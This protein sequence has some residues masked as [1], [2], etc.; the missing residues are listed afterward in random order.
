[1]K[2][3]TSVALAILLATILLANACTERVVPV[4]VSE[5]RPTLAAGEVNQGD[6]VRVAILAIRSAVAAQAQYGPLLDYLS[7]QTG[8]PFVF[9]PV[10]Q[11]DQF[12]VVERGKVDFTF[13]NPLAAV[14]IRRL[15][16]TDFLATLSRVN[17]GPEFSALIITRADSDIEAVE[18]LHDRRV[19]CV[20]HE[21]A[22]AGCVFQIFHLMEAGLDPFSDFATF[23]EEPS[24]DNIVLGVLN[25]TWDAG[26]V[27]TSHRM[28]TGGI[29]AIHSGWKV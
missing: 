12:T 22:A 17:T 24:Q 23:D 7:A 16:D 2:H 20:D 3:S 8:R 11:E 28:L 6:E 13:N 27:R 26:F 18:G 10:G 5:L 29:V 19:A 21:T 25:G 9:V 15:Y 1:M 4:A 14:Q